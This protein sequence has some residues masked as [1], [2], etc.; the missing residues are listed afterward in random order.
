[1]STVLPSSL[2]PSTLMTAPT[3]P[4]ASAPITLPYPGRDPQ[5]PAV[6]VMSFDNSPTVT[7]M[8]GN[9]P[10]GRRFD[11]AWLAI[12]HV[13]RHSRG[14][15][16]V[17]LLSF[18]QP[19][20]GN[21]SPRPISSR[22]QLA[23]LRMGLRVPLDVYGSSDLGPS[24]HVAEQIAGAR[25]EADVWFVPISDFWLTDDD[26]TAT[27]QRLTEFPGRVL[28]VVLGAQ[29][30]DLPAGP[31]VTSVQIDTDSPAGS[32]ALALFGALTATRR[33]VQT[34]PERNAHG[35]P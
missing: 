7:S 11:E 23:D 18:D 17:G 22:L 19:S 21:V 14:G 6:V 27:L 4:Q 16:L 2:A 31:R 1:M 20:A 26:P 8:G 10:V 30:P 34:A 24:L 15:C 3:S 9:D 13:A 35:Q 5:R 12:K 33:G 29:P 25:P 28:A 32:L